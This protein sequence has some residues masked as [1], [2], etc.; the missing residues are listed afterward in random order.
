MI[1]LRENKVEE[2]TGRAFKNLE[3]NSLKYSGVPGSENEDSEIIKRAVHALERI[4]DISSLAHI[5]EKSKHEEIKKIAFKSAKRA[6]DKIVEMSDSESLE[7]LPRRLSQIDCQ[8][9]KLYPE[10]TQ[11]KIRVEYKPFLIEEYRVK[12]IEK[13]RN[14][15]S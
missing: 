5:T 13:I 15:S 4:R 6:I 2:T 7:N 10:E 1:E 8:S 12:A 3:V 9:I 11:K 14:S